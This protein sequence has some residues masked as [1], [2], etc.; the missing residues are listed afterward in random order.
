MGDGTWMVYGANGYTGELIAEEAAR[1]GMTPIL[2]GRRERAVRPIAER[3]D[4]DCRV[5]TLDHPDELAAQLADVDALVLAAGPFSATSR[6][7]VDACIAS[8]THY[9]DITGE[10]AVFEA[11]R[12]RDAEAKAAGIAVIPGVGFDVVPSDCL[13]ASLKQAL[14]SA[15]SLEL[16]F[17]GDGSWSR[18]T[19]KTMVEGMGEGGAIREDGRI[20]RVAPAWRSRKVP[21]R[22]RPRTCVSIPWGDVST[23]Y[24]STG[25]PNIVVYMYMPQRMRKAVKAM[26]PLMPM[27]SWKP[28]QNLIKA[29]IEHAITGPD[30]ET[31]ESG[32]SQLWGCVTDADGNTVEGTL[33][34]P[35]GYKLTAMAT[36]ESVRRVLDGVS[37]GALTPSMAFGAGFVTELEGCDL[38]IGSN[39]AAASAQQESA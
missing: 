27:L 21:F 4:L 7:A 5:F 33:V 34:A 14:P 36:V 10:I 31:R 32:H 15:T 38:Q 23:A 16:A 8:K 2:A 18:G 30:E 12:R 29:G 11:C 3:L 9:L 24:H 20:R 25:I 26:T 37:A 6:P 22:D 35:E 1:R 13:A 17:A 28:L 19:A 39:G